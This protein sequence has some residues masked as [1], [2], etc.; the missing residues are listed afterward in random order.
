MDQEEKD[1]LNKT[2][3]LS[4]ENSHILKGIRSSNRWAS[5]VRILYWIIIIGA[6]VAAYYFIQPYL[7]TAIKAYNSV[8]S[9]IPG[10]K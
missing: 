3:E 9:I 1:L 2:Y 5:F 7:N 8:K 4:K 10:S 6:S